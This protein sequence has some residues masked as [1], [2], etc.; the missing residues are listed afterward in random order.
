MFIS[1]VF[2]IGT[3]ACLILEGTYFGQREFDILNS[4]T[5]Y[6]IV[7]V[8]GAGLWSIPKLGVGFMLHGLP[9]LIL[10]DFSFFTGGWFLF[11]VVLI[12]T[13]SVGVVW[14][15]ITMFISFGQGIL[16]QFMGR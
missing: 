10:W 6:T 11:R 7:Q 12:A 5:G 9:K 13:L 16:S 15:V 8:S 14:G 2:L 4:L 1:F 3:L